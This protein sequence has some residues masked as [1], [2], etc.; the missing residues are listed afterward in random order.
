MS[1]YKWLI[2]IYSDSITNSLSKDWN[3]QCDKVMIG[4]HDN[5]HD[6]EIDYFFSSHLLNELEDED[7]AFDEAKRLLVLYNGILYLL[8][9]THYRVS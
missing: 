8:N 1:G 9:V 5:F 4:I 2:D 3:C 6:S 7:K